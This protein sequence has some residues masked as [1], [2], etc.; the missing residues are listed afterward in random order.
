MLIATTS[1]IA[2]ARTTT[3][4]AGIAILVVSGSAVRAA[5]TELIRAMTFNLRFASDKKPNSWPER[6][7]WYKR[8]VWG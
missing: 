3:A 8:L 1:L 4:L 6:R 2:L 5:D 7:P